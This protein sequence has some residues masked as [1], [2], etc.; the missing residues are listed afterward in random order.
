[1]TDTTAPPVP[2]HMRRNGVDPVPELAEMRERE[3]VRRITTALGMSAWL[4][5][6]PGD[7]RQVL[8]DATRFSN[9]SALIG[10]PE[11]SDE[12]ERARSRA[13]LLL[14]LDPPEHSRLRRMLT[15][16]FTAG[17][18]RR[19]EPRVAAIVEEHL[20]ALAAAGPPADLVPSFALPV[21]SLVISELLGV[22]VADRESFQW[23]AGRQF[24]LSL[25]VDELRHAAVDSR[26][27][28]RTL[29]VAARA[30]P[31]ED[32]LGMLVRKHGDDVTDDELVGIGSLLLVAGHETTSNMLS[33]G[34]LA[35]LRHPA[36][37]ALVRDDPAAAGPAVEELLRYLSVVHTGVAR[38]ARVDLEL[39]G[40]PIAAGDLLLCSLPSVNRAVGERPDELDVARGAPGHVAFGHGVHH[41]IGAPLARMELRIALPALL[42]RFPDLALAVP[43]EEPAYRELHTAYGVHAL[44]VTW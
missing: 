29:V 15:P 10:L 33:L 13:G 25:P 2:L 6:R 27:Y 4:V 30:D 36:Q 21:P 41:C 42:R 22:P 14:V 20:D 34:L 9:A 8:S 12:Q 31:G 26:A 40:Q 5:A 28:M 18:M 37:L 17:R 19:L 35:L 24:D 43:D 7:V 1:M 39:A 23:R 3:G 38:T 44:P 32:L 16:E 11:P